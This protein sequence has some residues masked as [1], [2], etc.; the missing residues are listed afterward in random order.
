MTE[1]KAYGRRSR[2]APPPDEMAGLTWETV[3]NKPKTGNPRLTSAGAY[4]RNDVT[5]GFGVGLTDNGHRSLE[6]DFRHVF[7]MSKE[8]WD[9]ASDR[10]RAEMLARYEQQCESFARQQ[11]QKP[12]DIAT[13]WTGVVIINMIWLVAAG[14]VPNDEYNGTLFIW[15][16]EE[17]I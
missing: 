8:Q 13:G 14:R 15:E 1:L 4:L 17:A 11:R 6:Q 10:E 16:L 2:E 3:T 9:E 5:G 12:D 7:E